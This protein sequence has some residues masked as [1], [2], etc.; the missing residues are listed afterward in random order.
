VWP[1][2]PPGPHEK[3]IEHIET[4]PP[5]S[6]LLFGMHPNAEIGFRTAQCYQLFGLLMMLQPKDTSGGDDASENVSP[7]AKAEGMT[8]DF[9]DETRDINFPVE[10]LIRSMSD[11]EKGP[12]QFV[13]LQECE[14]MNVLV[15]EMNRSLAELQLGFKGELTMSPAMEDLAECLHTELIYAKWSKYGFPS[16]RA[17]M[18]WLGNLKERCDQLNDWVAEPLNIP[19]V[20][21]ISK[22]FNPQSFLTA[23]KQLCCQQQQLELDKLQVFT[24]VTK[25]DAK[26]VDAAARDGAFVSGMFLE[27]ARWDLNSNSLEESKPKEMFFR[28]PVINCRAGSVADKEEKNIYICPTYCVPTR[29]PYYVFPAQLRTKQPAAKWIMGGVAIILDVGIAI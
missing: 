11:E 12:Y 24:E 14:Y 23:I 3:Y 4:M 6:P 20:V 13:F 16:T 21:D 22:L 10:D 26:G 1:S 27:G 8:N 9:L 29:R 2:P 19:K 17:L 25:R 15:G 28:L 18:S 5:E 7:M